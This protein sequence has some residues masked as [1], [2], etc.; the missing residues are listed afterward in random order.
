MQINISTFVRLNDMWADVLALNKRLGAVTAV[1]RMR[2]LPHEQDQ[3]LHPMA[4]TVTYVSPQRRAILSS[5]LCTIM[6]VVVVAIPVNCE[7]FNTVCY[8]SWT[9]SF[10]HSLFV[11]LFGQFFVRV[12]I[13]NPNL[14]NVRSSKSNCVNV[15]PDMR[16][17]EP[18]H[19]SGDNPPI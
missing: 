11:T 1:C 6:T 19:L 7:W 3:S 17:I 2:S 13:T 5:L 8:H 16:F 4:S 14:L 15:S 18:L 9:F 10:I 12:K